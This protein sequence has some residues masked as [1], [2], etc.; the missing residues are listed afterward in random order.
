MK[1]LFATFAR[2]MH[3]KPISC[4]RGSEIGL[5]AG[6]RCR[7]VMQNA[8][9]GDFAQT[10]QG[11]AA[12]HNQARRLRRAAPPGYMKRPAPRRP[13]PTTFVKVTNRKCQL[14]QNRLQSI[15]R[16]LPRIAKIDFMMSADVVNGNQAS[17]ALGILHHRFN[18]RR[19]II[20]RADVHALYAQPL[21]V[22]EELHQRG[23]VCLF[24]SGHI[25]PHQAYAQ[26]HHRRKR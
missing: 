3:R 4:Q 22:W 13:S 8:H 18:R 16:R 20:I 23:D 26:S 24:A 10:R 14:Y 1:C 17:L 7:V 25:S 12:L 11:D 2:R 21:I 19:F 15:C 6:K 5:F 9:N